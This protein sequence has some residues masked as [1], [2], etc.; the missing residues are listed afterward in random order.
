ME[1]CTLDWNRK[2][3]KFYQVLDV[4]LL[5][6]CRLCHLTTP[7][8]LHHRLPSL[9]NSQMLCNA[10]VVVSLFAITAKLTDALQRHG[11]RVAIHHHCRACG[12]MSLY[13]VVVIR[14][15]CRAHGCRS[16]CNV[17]AVALSFVVRPIII[18]FHPLTSIHRCPSTDVHPPSFILVNVSY[19]SNCLYY[20]YTYF[21]P[22][23]SNYMYVFF[24]IVY[25]FLK[26]I[27]TYIY[28]LSY[29]YIHLR[30][31]Y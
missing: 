12:R 20:V 23:S 25:R 22:Y 17:M 2:A 8:P 1:W 30:I 29:Q 3:V 21:I 28:I 26:K 31:S 11:H 10:M 14:H 24:K 27:N 13:N 19:S 4:A 9:Q 18:A 16:L 15:H 5:L 6:E 7:W